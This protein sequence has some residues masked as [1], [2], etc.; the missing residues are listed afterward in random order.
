MSTSVSNRTVA[1]WLLL[2]SCC[3]AIASWRALPV[4]GNTVAPAGSWDRESAARY[5]DDREVWWQAWP[6]AQKDHGTICI[7]CHTNVP[8]AMVRPELQRDLG[9]PA[10]TAAENTM[11]AS[12]EKRVSQWS[13]MTPFYLDSK[14]G[15]GKTV[16]SH[17]TE[18]VLNAV[19]LASYDARLGHLR[20]ITRTAFDNAWALQETAGDKAGAWKWQDFH[21]GPWEASESGYQGAALLLIE[22]TSLPGGYAKEPDVRPHLDWLRD[23]LRRQYAAQPLMNQLY[24][25]WASAKSPGLLTAPQRKA[26]L[27]TLQA[28]QQPDGGWRTTAMDERER[29]DYSP[30]PTE[31]DGYATGLAV[32]AMEESGTSR[33]EPV[34]KHGLDWLIT[35]QQ[36]DGTWNASSI[37]KQRDPANDATPFMKDAA[38][39]YAAL[40][41][42]QAR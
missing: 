25:L 21:L 27:A 37:N 38:T 3:A 17:A 20:P 30:E 13:E 34:L 24:V 26:L 10:M 28:Q 6:R 8:Y 31:S 15:S 16:E 35:N 39:A 29:V 32:L 19:I 36:K 4:H 7:S 9:E 42:D 1:T 40:A 14:Y 33:R 5:L 11:M 41:L 12:V 2:G 23:Y 18:A 22:A